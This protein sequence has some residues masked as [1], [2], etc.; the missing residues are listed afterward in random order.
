[1]THNAAQNHFENEIASCRGFQSKVHGEAALMPQEEFLASPNG[2]EF[3]QEQARQK[4][5]GSQQGLYNFMRT[6]TLL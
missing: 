4:A 3:L 2:Q 6:R 5:D 1:M